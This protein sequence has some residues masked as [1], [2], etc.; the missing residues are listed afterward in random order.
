MKKYYQWEFVDRAED[1]NRKMRRLSWYYGP[2]WQRRGEKSLHN[3]T[4]EPTKKFDEFGEE[5]HLDRYITRLLNDEQ[6]RFGKLTLSLPKEWS[7]SN[8]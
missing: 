5:L 4:I 8:I 6:V 2:V 7:V 3:I 1:A